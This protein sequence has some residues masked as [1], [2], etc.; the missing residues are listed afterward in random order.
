M[1]SS[2]SSGSDD[3]HRPEYEPPWAPGIWELLRNEGV[4]ETEDEGPLIYVTSY[5]VSHTN[6]PFC[7]EPRPLRFDVDFRDWNRDIRVV[8]EDVVDDA[9]PLDVV[10]VQPAPPH[11]AI[12]GT[13]ATVIVQQHM[14]PDRHS[15]LTT[16]VYIADPVTH[17]R[18]AAHSVIPVLPFDTV[19]QL[20][21]TDDTCRQRLEQGYGRCT[22]HVGFQRLPID[23]AI[24][25]NTG[26]G[27]TVRVPAS[28]TSAEAEDNLVSRTTRSRALRPGDS[29]DPGTD[30][31][32]EL[33][34]SH[35]FD[36]VDPEDEVSLMTRYTTGPEDSTALMARRPQLHQR[37]SSW[38]RSRS[39][40]SLSSSTASSSHTSTATANWCQ[41]I[42]FSLN[43]RSAS[44]N[45]P[46][47]DRV[48]MR[49]LIARDFMLFENE[50]LHL[51]RVSHR[52]GDYIEDDLQCIILQHQN[53]QPQTPTFMIVLIDLEV[54]EPLDFQPT[55]LR[56]FVRWVPTTL[57]RQSV[58]RLLGLEQQ[59]LNPLLRCTLWHNNVIIA[60]DF[61]G[62]LSIE[63][64][65]YIRALVRNPRCDHHPQVYAEVRD[66]LSLM[67]Q[68]S[69]QSHD[70]AH[71][72]QC[73]FGT[74]SPHRYYQTVTHVSTPGDRPHS[75]PPP[76]DSSSH[77]MLPVG[78]N[79]MEN[80]RADL[81][82]GDA[83]VE[84]VTWYL[85]IPFHPRCEE[86]RILHVDVEQHLWYRDLCE[87]W[88]DY[89][90]PH[91][92]T[93]VLVVDPNPP[94]AP[95]DSHV[96][97]LIL[98]QGDFPGHVPTLITAIFESALGRRLMHLACYVPAFPSNRDII[99]L[100][101]L[102]R[103][104]YGQQRDCFASVA[105]FDILDDG[106]AEVHEGNHVILTVP[107][108]P[109]E[110]VSLLQHDVRL[111][112][113]VS[114]GDVQSW[115]DADDEKGEINITQSRCESPIL[116][117]LHS[118]TDAFLNAVRLF[119]Q[120]AEDAPEFQ[121]DPD[122]DLDNY[123]PWVRT[124]YEAWNSMAT[125]GPGGVERLARLETWY[126]D[127][128]NF[129]RCHFT[130][131]AILGGDFARWEQEIRILWR[132]HIVHGAP[133]E[134][135]TV[136]PPPE[137]AAAQTIGQ[138]VLVQRPVR[139][140]RSLIIS[141]Y[142]SDY[143]RGMAHSLAVVMTDRVDLHAVRSAV[144]AVE[145]CPPEVA[146][147]VC[148]LWF[149]A[150]Q[151]QPHERFHARHGHAFRLLI[152]R[153]PADAFDNMSDLDDPLLRDRIQHLSGLG[154]LP[155]PSALAVISPGWA[156][157]LYR[158]FAEH[159]FVER[160]DEGPIAYVQT[161]QLNGLRAPRCHHPRTV[162]LRSDASSWQR[163]ITDLWD[164]RLDLRIPFDIFWIEPPPV[165]SPLQSYVGHLIILQEPQH[166]QAALLLT[167]IQHGDAPLEPRHVAVCGTD[168]LSSSNIVDLFPIPGPLLQRPTLVRRDQFLWPARRSVRVNNGDNIIIEIQQAGFAAAGSSPDLQEENG[169]TSLLQIHMNGV[170]SHDDSESSSRERLTADAVAHAQRPRV[171]L[172]LELLVSPPSFLRI[173]FRAVQQVRHRI[174]YD[175]PGVTF[176]RAN[177]VK[178]HPSTVEVFD[179]M[180]D[181]LEEPAQ[182]FAFFT[183]GSALRGAHPPRSAAAVVLIVRTASGDRFGGFRCFDT[184]TDG[185]APHAEAAAMFMATIWAAQLCEVWQPNTSFELSFHF[186][187]LFAGFTAQGLW[188]AV[189]HDQLQC[190]TRALVHW[191]SSRFGLAP[192]W[193]HV[194]AHTGHP[195]NEAADAIAWAV[196]SDWIQPENF[197]ELYDHLCDPPFAVAWL[198]M[199]ESPSA[200]CPSVPAIVDG[201]MNLNVSQAFDPVPVG[202][203][204]PFVLRND[205][206]SQPLQTLQLTLRCATANVLTLY[207][208]RAAH[209]NG[210]TARLE[211]L[212]QSFD[213]ENV[214]VVG[215]QE[216]RSRMTGHT[217][218]MGFHVLSAPATDKGVG[219]VQLWVKRKWMTSAGPVIITP[220]HL[221]IVHSTS[222]TMAVQLSHHDLHLLFL[223]G[224]APSCPSDAD[225]IG[226]W[227]LM[228]ESIPSSSRSW[229]TIA[230]L[231]ANARVGS[232][233]SSAIGPFGAEDENTAGEHFHQWLHDP[234]LFLPQ[235]FAEYHHGD[236]ATW[237]HSS[238][239]VA[240]L[241]YIAIDHSL[242]HPSVCTQIANVDLTLRKEDH[243]SVQ[244]DIPIFCRMK[245]VD[246]GRSDH[247]IEHSQPQVPVVPWNCDVHT[248]AA[249]IQNWMRS[250]VPPRQAACPRKSHLWDSTWQ[251]IRCKRYHWTRIRQLRR[252]R[253]LAVM[254]ELFSV[255]KTGYVH[256]DVSVFAPWLRLSDASLALHEWQHRRLC[257][258]VAHQVRED[259]RVFYEGLAEQQSA[260]AADE[261]L[262][263]L[264]RHLR[265]VLPK[266]IKK[267]RSNI[268]C[269]GPHVDELTAHY[270]S[271]EAGQEV[272]YSALLT[273]CHMRQKSCID[274]LPLEISLQDLPSR[275]EIEQVCKLAKRGRAPGLDSVQ[276]EHLQFLMVNHSDV[277]HHL[278]FKVW[279][280]SAEPLQWKGGFICSIAKK[281][282]ART[283]SGMRGI[284]LLDSLAKLHHALLRRH[285]LPWASSNRLPTQYGG[286]RGQQ[287]LFAALQ[288][289]S[290]VRF[291]EARQLSLAIVFIDVR[292]AFHCLLRQHAFD[293]TDEFPLVLSALL[294]KEGLDVTQLFRDVRAHAHQFES[295][296]PLAARLMKDAHVNTWFTCPLTNQCFETHRGS[297]PGSPLADLAYNILMSAV[298]RQLQD[299][300]S[301]Q[302]R[303]G[304]A[305][306]LL[307][308]MS[309]IVT[310]VDDVALP[311]PCIE[312]DQMDGLL[313]DTTIL[314]HQTFRHFGLRLNC[315]AGKTEAIILYRG[316]G[317]PDLRRHRFLEGFGQ[318]E[319]TGHEP[320]RLVPT[321]THLG[322]VV[323]QNLDVQ[324]DIHVK[325]GKATTAYRTMSRSIFLNRR[326]SI[327]LRLKLLET[328]V[329][330]IL[331]YGCGSW[332]LL[333]ATQYRALSSIITKWQR[334]IAG[335][336]FWNDSSIT[337][338]AFRAHWRLPSLAVRLAKHRLLFF[339]QLHRH[340]PQTVWDFVLAE[341]EYCRKPWLD[342]VR[343]ALAWFAT[344]DS[345]IPA[346]TWSQAD[347]L[348]WCATAPSTM[349]NQIRRAVA[350]HLTQ[351]ETAHH[352]LHMH[353]EIKLLCGR[354][355]VQFDQPPLDGLHLPDSFSCSRCSRSFSTAQGLNAHTWKAHGVIS[356]ERKYV[357]SGVC[358][359]CRKCFWT[360][361]RLQQHLKYS[362]SKP[363]G[364]FAWLAKHYDPLQAPLPVAM[365]EI[366][367]HQHRL[368]WTLASGPIQ[369]SISSCWMRKH[370]RDGA[371]WQET[372]AQEGF[373]EELSPALCQ[374]VHADV[375]ASTNAWLRDPESDL[376][377]IWC[378]V[379]ERY[380]DHGDSV[381]LQAMW[382]FALWGRCELY[383]LL[384]T[385][386]DVDL[387]QH[388]ES[389]YLQLT[390]DLPVADLLDRLERLQRAVPPASVSQSLPAAAP[391]LRASCPLEPLSSAYSQL[392]DLLGPIVNPEVLHWPAA[393]GVPVCELEDGQQVLIILHLFSGRRRAD[394][395]HDWAHRLIEQF[396]PG[397]GVL[398]LSLDTA[399]GGELCNLLDGP[400]LDSLH[401]VVASGLVSGALSGPPCETWSAARHLQ[402][403]DHLMA[404]WPRPL[405]SAER[406]WGLCFLTHRELRQLATGSALMLSNIKI[407]LHVVLN[408]GASILEHPE[409]PEQEAYAS[410]WRTPLQDRLCRAVPGHQRLHIQQWRFGAKAVKPT[411]LRALGLPKCAAVLHGLAMDDCERPQNVLSGVDS[412]TGQFKTACAKEYPPH[413]C[414]AL[415]FTLLNGL[416][417]R[418]HAEGA[419]VRKISLLGERDRKCS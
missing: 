88:N 179:H 297:R 386:E 10:V 354:Y 60:P 298:L 324:Q 108:R 311:V 398:V 106:L 404:R 245:T 257:G 397:F 264:W 342:A 332:P 118:F 178:W 117:L 194:P 121:L 291:V 141:V 136:D 401:R 125:L 374:Q 139:F 173:D 228:T 350:R 8:W 277:F 144:D 50:I 239:T 163:S 278:L 380:A 389:Q 263:G 110:A 308:F 128:L 283:A 13:V 318:L 253:R 190:H 359:C 195:W 92:P 227:N 376:S 220:H 35:D 322:L 377:W 272:S 242:Q 249:Q 319:I 119:R 29:F 164:D 237:T 393:K 109:S 64:G 356:E 384:D 368:P 309:P 294:E 400:G 363:D 312:A 349:P 381:H 411:L 200:F 346:Q 230:L 39:G 120:A 385:I 206:D 361:Q 274:D 285:L 54:Y 76:S 5:F 37:P 153:R 391:D 113:P 48:Q 66:E 79:L 28:M 339:L 205:A 89:L 96:G 295:A 369:E 4:V 225:A 320:L 208:N 36:S 147:N 15:I 378:E 247:H 84:W 65:D 273:R 6:H 160:G 403:P 215:V 269:S 409:I 85:G 301:V 40:S 323:A 157:D 212:L 351:E 203:S 419:C 69:L 417:R 51:H 126:T 343:H 177:V 70:S 266:S 71:E 246:A 73:S 235:T 371:V 375:T 188:R 91:T 321:Y 140:Q 271:L 25:V 412:S 315:S 265:H 306:A 154:P 275:V 94:R 67:Q 38:S 1:A 258:Q 302:P 292:N 314:V 255:W 241:D 260:V 243:S 416:S 27:L 86:T 372:W 189:A 223:V 290:F 24:L 299:A 367:R 236:H 112:D 22:I 198:W 132:D 280:M 186:D 155:F 327:I 365:P 20:S 145:D 213:H 261:G 388:I 382:A 174:L 59:C 405:R 129:Q 46:W 231:D 252:L 355:G 410:V 134:F 268:R 161:W 284:M 148:A 61:A 395:C 16:A 399:I 9:A 183:D 394:D 357:F 347:L 34:Q 296:P 82:P 138:L 32:P 99:G 240:R 199:L 282:G 408:G 187:C 305:H 415:V 287:T 201:F 93:K 33:H 74:T 26:L 30:E 31:T 383:D 21:G 23:Q 259:D 166:A 262:T 56:R 142:D 267:R 49:T 216:T 325:L 116:P 124:V 333:S 75:L 300:V 338:A 146:Q 127:H 229:P 87:L 289:R 143:D 137:D 78:M 335:Q 251:L 2:S 304:Q 102:D 224:H 387:K 133:L 17:F 180:P 47:G 336:G 95:Y 192:T 3:T 281:H 19:L 210:L 362:R 248:H 221:R 360:S 217:T 406:A 114:S 156:Q 12:R 107:R 58:L 256:D 276:A 207:Q 288:L 185:H 337:D 68:T 344:M 219:G 53:D 293:T 55:Q 167:A 135:H 150:R 390:S 279:T 168:R 250:S 196:V 44:L 45:L 358:E 316:K 204:H 123:D 131:V 379:I 104:C 52:P 170:H 414:K 100:L 80:L 244:I 175:S 307:G 172:Q 159:S 313:H 310:W 90:L 286:F 130:R 14:I 341:D 62:A 407:E 165:N 303:I 41:T 328:L 11:Q 348:Q 182:G 413:L 270:C 181:W 345:N 101:G 193:H 209:G 317:A 366:F 103:I 396:F 105:G 115:C 171:P 202:T 98:V 184:S 232:C 211:S 152:H 222:Q 72:R 158:A 364:C 330:P 81:A 197:S 353:Q 7:D 238:G 402:P 418:Y 331:F 149:G 334:Q 254:R 151:M 352:V 392:P 226:F 214:L 63:D 122:D 234:A 176:S 329:L 169:A 162:R 373:P 77:W 218:C 18:D 43:G 111:S 57:T 326:L 83:T 233:T 340:G 191:L 42:V 97:H 370:A